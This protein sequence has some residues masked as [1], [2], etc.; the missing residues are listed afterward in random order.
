MIWRI[1]MALCVCFPVHAELWELHIFPT[2][3]YDNGTVIQPSELESYW[4]GCGRAQ[5]EYNVITAMLLRA[6]G[7]IDPEGVGKFRQDFDSGEWFC[8]ARTRT[9]NG[10]ESQ[11]SNVFSFTAGTGNPPPP[12]PPPGRPRPPIITGFAVQ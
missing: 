5:G 12:P 11:R 10:N 1:L 2:W 7:Q 6:G 8:V 3:E 9:T 4:I